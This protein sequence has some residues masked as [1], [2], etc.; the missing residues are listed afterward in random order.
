M[1]VN[2]PE[3]RS[4]SA[5]VTDATVQGTGA[6]NLTVTGGT[7]PYNF[8]WTS[9]GVFLSDEE[10]VDG[11]EA[12]DE[13]SVLVTDANGCEIAG[14]PYEVDDVYSVIQLEGVP[15]GLPNP[16]RSGAARHERNGPRCRDVHLRCFRPIDVVSCRRT[17]DR[18]VHRGCVE[19][20]CWNVP[21]PSGDCARR[22]ACTTCGS[23][24][25]FMMA[26][27]ILPDSTKKRP[28]P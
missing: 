23:A 15:F 6:I 8:E 14:G 26:E 9:D 4:L 12:P 22:G 10:D 25:M 13:Y 16:A 24:L 17:L 1:T 2:E 27:R 11:L 21:R 19:L 7:A 20:V 28:R 5:V 3:A 18:N